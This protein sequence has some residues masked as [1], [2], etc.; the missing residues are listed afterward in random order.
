LPLL[1]LKLFGLC[2]LECKHSRIPRNFL[3]YGKAGGWSMQTHS[4]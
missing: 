3:V 4:R 2:G 1:F